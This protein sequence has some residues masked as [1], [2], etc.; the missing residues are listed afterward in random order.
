LNRYFH[1]HPPHLH[2]IYPSA[3]S[4]VVQKNLC[5]EHPILFTLYNSFSFTIVTVSA[6]SVKISDALTGKL[7]QEHRE[8]IPSSS[9]ICSAC[10]D[11]RK[12]KIIIGTTEGHV[13]IFN[14]NSGAKM[15]L[16]HTFEDEIAQLSYVEIKPNI[17][18]KYY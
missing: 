2:G 16:L 1:L 14:L 12:R 3:K 17:K 7:T 11:H 5:D 4:T 8:F 15:A 10:L 18:R 9:L 6:Y 13:F